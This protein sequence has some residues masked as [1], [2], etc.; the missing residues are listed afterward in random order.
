MLRMGFLLALFVAVSG[1]GGGGGGDTTD[2]PDLTPERPP[3]SGAWEGQLVY[4]NSQKS[5]HAKLAIF[6]GTAWIKIEG[7][8]AAGFDVE[9]NGDEITLSSKLESGWP[10][11]TTMMGNAFKHPAY[12]ETLFDSPDIS[13]KFT[14][15]GRDAVGSFE[16]SE[17]GEVIEFGVFSLLPI[18]LE[19][20]RFYIRDIPEAEITCGE[21][22]GYPLYCYS[23]IDISVDAE[24]RISGSYNDYHKYN[25]RPS[26]MYSTIPSS[27]DISGDISSTQESGFFSMTMEAP[28]LKSEGFGYRKPN[29]ELEYCL[30]SGDVGFSPS[31]CP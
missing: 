7:A 23:D 30:G 19:D 25:E 26:T 12:K 16:I 22:G 3:V 6:D 9:R 18:I 2:Q 17:S 14:L 28:R 20:G 11:E 21:S 29:G 31:I 5:E 1:C 13:L 24:G 8:K 4:Q 27:F 10:Q 15:Q